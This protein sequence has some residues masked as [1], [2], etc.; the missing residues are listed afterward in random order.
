MADKYL[1]LVS[2]I[3]TGT[4]ATISSAGA[5]DSGKIVAL[6]TSGLLSIT[7]M[8]VGVTADVRLVVASENLAAG[9]LVNLWNDGGTL[10]ARKAIAT[11]LGTRA[12][13]F[14][15]SAFSTSATATVY[16]KGNNDQLSGLTAGDFLFLSATAGLVTATA[17]TTSGQ[18]AQQVG[19]AITATSATIDIDHIA[20]N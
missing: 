5:G 6:D 19:Q 9:D 8:P 17:P 7:M 20:V 11:G 12:S 18:V 10:K 3:P 1:K 13:G 14:V 2:G 15:L 16:I 4:E